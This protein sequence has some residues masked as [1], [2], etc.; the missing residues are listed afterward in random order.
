MEGRRYHRRHG[1]AWLAQGQS[2]RN[3]GRNN[4]DV[5]TITIPVLPAQIV[6]STCSVTMQLQV[7]V[8]CERTRSTHTFDVAMSSE[9]PDQ[10]EVA[11]QL[12]LFSAGRVTHLAG[13]IRWVDVCLH[14]QGRCAVC[15]VN[16]VRVKS[17]PLCAYARRCC[18]SLNHLA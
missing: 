4:C 7:A 12:G 1:A 5:T 13:R 2:W 9:E 16:R 10:H 17:T 3:G 15:D 6:R 18:C 11:R 14:R 8:T